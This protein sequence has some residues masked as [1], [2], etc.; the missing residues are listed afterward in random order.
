MMV[1]NTW[2][3]Q[4]KRRRYTWKMPGDRKRYQLDYILLGQRYRNGVKNCRARP[5]ADCNSDHNLVRLDMRIR[6]KRIRYPKIRKRI[7]LEVLK[8]TEGKE[9]YREEVTRQLSAEESP[10]VEG[11]WNYCG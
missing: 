11:R 1:A 7:N 2:F 3:N 10:G 5:G 4:H 6:L 9:A 8:E